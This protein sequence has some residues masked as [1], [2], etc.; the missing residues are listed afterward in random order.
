MRDIVSNSEK[1]Y[2]VL[3]LSIDVVLSEDLSLR[4]SLNYRKV[5]RRR[6]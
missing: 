6:P 2:I 1:Y 4:G 5:A 3:H